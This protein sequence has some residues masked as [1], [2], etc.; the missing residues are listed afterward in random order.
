[1]KQL[2]LIL[3]S[4]LSLTAFAQKKSVA[5]LN[6]ICVDN[7][8]NTFYQQIVRGA[9]ESAVT[10]TDEYDPF[11]RTAFDKVLEEHHFERSGAVNDSQIRQMGAYAGVDFVIVSEASACQGY[12]TVLV[13]IVNIETGET[14]K[15]L[16]KLMEETPPVVQK[17]CE[18]LAMKLFG[19][20]DFD[21]GTRKGTL[22]LDEGRYEGEI[23]YGK[24]MVKEKY[25]FQQRIKTIGNLMRVIG[26]KE[27]V[28]DRGQ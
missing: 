25:I 26:W 18:G 16:S 21:S 11:D 10:A 24:Q 12:M 5:V 28:R 17:S 6:P 15:G 2:F 14:S 13:K 23:Q 3:L 20:V 22:Q 19:I 27:N 7:S 8:V 1:M 4:V 9:M